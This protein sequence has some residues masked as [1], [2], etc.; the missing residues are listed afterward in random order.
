[1]ASFVLTLISCNHEIYRNA[2]AF[3]PIHQPRSSTF[4]GNRCVSTTRSSCGDNLVRIRRSP[5]VASTSTAIT[6]TDASAAAASSS[7]ASEGGGNEESSSSSSSP[8]EPQKQ[9]DSNGN[10]FTVGRIVRVVASDL[11]A[12]HVMPKGHGKFDP[13]TK[14]FIPAPGGGERGVKNLVIPV[15]LRGVVTRVYDTHDIGS[16]LPILVKFAPGAN[17]EEGFDPPVPFIMHFDSHEVECVV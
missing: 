2:T 5:V 15:G 12:Y 17:V 4:F 3:T 1:M 9:L 16:N 11:K 10:E 8:P 6:S 13:T 14:E 7:S